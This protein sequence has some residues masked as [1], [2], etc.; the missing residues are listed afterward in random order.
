MYF[1]IDSILK[2]NENCLFDYRLQY[3]ELIGGVLILKT[4]HLLASNGYSNL[5]WGWGAEDDDLYYRLKGL[6]YKV[7]R[8][9]IKIGRYK[10]MKHEK[11]KPQLWSKR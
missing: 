8:P 4:E 7:E 5:Y 10:M 9:P 3:E 11:R 2:L 1:F 6:G